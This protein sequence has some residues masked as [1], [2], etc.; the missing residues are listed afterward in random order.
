MT[1][2]DKAGSQKSI[3]P[4]MHNKHITTPACG[5]ESPLSETPLMR[6]SKLC[7]NEP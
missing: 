4:E 5:Q 3:E 6:T 7:D 2:H 1:Y